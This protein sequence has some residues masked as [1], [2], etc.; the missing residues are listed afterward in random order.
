MVC[1]KVTV[2]RRG[3]GAGIPNGALREEAGSGGSR[4]SGGSSVRMG[5]WTSGTL[6]SSLPHHQGVLH[7][8]CT[9]D[10]AAHQSFLL[11]GN[12]S[13]NTFASQCRYVAPSPRMGSGGEH[14]CFQ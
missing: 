9:D 14:G 6:G 2:C 11:H 3:L 12:C 10:P 8:G 7:P 1:P 4:G 13:T 5:L